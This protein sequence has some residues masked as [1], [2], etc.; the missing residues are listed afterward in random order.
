MN[1][2][3]YEVLN[4]EDR[5]NNI[6]RWT[7]QGLKESVEKEMKKLVDTI[8]SHRNIFALVNVYNELNTIRARDGAPKGVDQKYFNELVYELDRFLKENTGDGGWQHPILFD[9]GA[10]K[11]YLRRMN[12]DE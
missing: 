6:C 8:L 12:P 2:K 7:N 3:V 4:I 9:H 10:I 11:N 1:D 5:V